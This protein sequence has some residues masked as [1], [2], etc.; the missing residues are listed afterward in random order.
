VRH[1]DVSAATSSLSCQGVVTSAALTSPPLH[2]GVFRGELMPTRTVRVQRP[3]RHAASPVAVG[4]QAAGTTVRVPPVHVA[5]LTLDQM[6]VHADVGSALLDPSQVRSASSVL[7]CCDNLH[8]R[9]VDAQ[10]ASTSFPNVVDG[11]AW[12]DGSLEEFPGDAMSEAPVGTADLI[13]VSVSIA[14]DRP[15]PQPTASA[16]ADE[17]PEVVAPVRG[18]EKPSCCRVATTHRLNV[19]WKAP[20]MLAKKSA[21]DDSVL[22]GAKKVKLVRGGGICSQSDKSPKLI[23]GSMKSAMCVPTP[24]TDPRPRY[25]AVGEMH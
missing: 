11:H 14:G 24:G 25:R 7:L 4:S 23:K 16:L 8:M 13:E 6:A 21:Q 18:L 22:L 5:I 15:C 17:G 20:I 3:G 19:L 2:K 9:R 10:A 1:V 12:R